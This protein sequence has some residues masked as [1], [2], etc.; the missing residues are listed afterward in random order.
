MAGSMRWG[1]SKKWEVESEKYKADGLP[2]QTSNPPHPAHSAGLF[3]LEKK[4]GSDG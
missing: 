4:V 3:P 1:R 2:L